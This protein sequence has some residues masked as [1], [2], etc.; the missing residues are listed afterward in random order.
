MRRTSSS[1]DFERQRRWC[2]MGPQRFWD[3]RYEEGSAPDDWYCDMNLLSPFLCW[4]LKEPGLELHQQSSIQLLNIGC[5]TSELGQ[6]SPLGI[7]VHELGVDASLPALH[8]RRGKAEEALLAADVTAL[9]LRSGF[10]DAVLDKGTLDWVL[11]S[12]LVSDE[13]DLKLSSLRR[14]LLRV[15]RPGGRLVVVT[16]LGGTSED[17]LRFLALDERVGWAS[18]QSRH[19]DGMD[20]NY[21]CHC[22]VRA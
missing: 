5:G 2:R 18:F 11:L 1:K 9:P 7:V 17:P 15:L 14:E 22:L 4:A 19:V 16:G 21:R 13:R 6:W 10:F 20:Q 3:R 12:L 8:S